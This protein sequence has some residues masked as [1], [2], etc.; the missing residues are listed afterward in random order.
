MNKLIVTNSAWG[1][2][3]SIIRNSNNNSFML[4]ATS[5]GCNGFNYKFKMITDDKYKEALKDNPVI[6]KNNGV[7]VLIEPKN[8]YLLSG[9]TIYYLKQDLKN[10]I[11]ESKFIFIPDKKLT[12]SCGCGNS[13][14]Y[15]CINE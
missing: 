5:G 15:R 2:L 13:F 10:G 6:E 11:F 1:K 7:N 4:S 12:Y 14:N 8:E 3:I 9:T